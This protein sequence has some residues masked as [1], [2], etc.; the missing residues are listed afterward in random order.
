MLSLTGLGLDTNSLKRFDSFKSWGSS[1]NLQ[2]LWLFSNQFTSAVPSSF[3]SF[4]TS[5]D[6]R[7][8]SNPA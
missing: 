8:Q 6:L 1:P 5:I 3:C 2:G 7:L 4:S